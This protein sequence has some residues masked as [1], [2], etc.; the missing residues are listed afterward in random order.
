MGY[1][2]EKKFDIIARLDT[3]RECDVQTTDTQRASD[4][5]ATYGALQMCFDLIDWLNDG[6]TTLT[7]SVAWY[8]NQNDQKRRSSDRKRWMVVTSRRYNVEQ[9]IGCISVFRQCLLV[10]PAWKFS[11]GNNVD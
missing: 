11:T 7:H 1:Q 2:A 10:Q 9:K 8:K 3:I 6:H 4:S 5:P